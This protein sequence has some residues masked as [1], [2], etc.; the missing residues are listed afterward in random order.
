MSEPLS[1]PADEFVLVR[2]VAEQAGLDPA[3]SMTPA[4]HEAWHAAMTP[5]LPAM[6]M[7]DEEAAEFAERFAVYMAENSLTHR[8]IPLPPPLSPDQIR[9]LLRECVTV[10]KPGEVLVIRAPGDWTPGQLRE[11]AEHLE[12]YAGEMGIRAMVVVGDELGVA[13]TV[14]GRDHA[15]WLKDVRY[16]VYSNNAGQSVRATHLPTGLQVTAATKD[17]ALADLASL[18]VSK[19]DIR[20]NDARAALGLPAWD[21]LPAGESAP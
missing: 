15:A 17:R 4:Q 20:V 12:Y 1:M 19:G 21:C 13:E 6:T 11:Y 10:V 7:T 16:D 14:P 18:L 3:A 5:D 2:R 8:V 9:S